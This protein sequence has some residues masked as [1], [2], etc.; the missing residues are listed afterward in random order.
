MEEEA[1]EEM[2]VERDASRNIATAIMEEAFPKEAVQM[3]FGAYIDMAAAKKNREARWRRSFPNITEIP[4]PL[5][6][7]GD[8]AE[9]FEALA[10]LLSSPLLS[11]PLLSSPGQTD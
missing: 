2:D 4:D 5:R 8:E 7:F 1:E 10:A 11:S 9:W 6:Q 3:F